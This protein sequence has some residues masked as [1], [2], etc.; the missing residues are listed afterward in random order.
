VSDTH[1]TKHNLP[2]LA[3]RVRNIWEMF[4]LGRRY[5]AEPLALIGEGFATFG[6]IHYYDFRG[7]NQMMIAD[8]EAIQQI[9]VSQAQKF[10]KNADYTDTKRGLARFLGNGLLTNEGDAWKRQRK[11]MQPAFHHKRIEGYAEHIVGST[12]AMVDGW[13][14]QTT[15]PIAEA[16]MALTLRIVVKSLFAAEAD[17]DTEQIGEAMDIIQDFTNDMH[18][19]PTWLPTP[20]ELRARRAVKLLDEVIYR[21]IKRRREEGEDRGDLL[22]MLLQTTD[23]EGIPM[24]D[25][26]IRDELVT[27]YLAGHETTANVLNWT[28]YLLA[29]NSTQRKALQTEID[30][31]LGGR[32][33]TLSDLKRLPYTEQVVKEAMRLYPPAWVFSRMA[34][35]DTVLGGYL[36]PQGS[37]IVVSLYHTHRHTALWGADA[38]Q[39]IPERFAPEREKLIP[40]Y[41]YLPFGAGARICIGNMFA[42]MEAQLILATIVQRVDLALH[43]GQE[44]KVDAKLT[45]RPQGRLPML[46]QRREMQA[47]HPQEFAAVYA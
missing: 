16:L 46:I 32:L 23:E 17:A 3:F 47:E 34:I 41:A 26:Q 18:L 11:L 24:S 42:M 20:L 28:F 15:I 36:I 21:L 45:M 40:R 25:K 6:D 1:I 22:S 31:V 27:L 2:P 14:G 8:P 39:F 30:G 44:V 7:Q 9:T 43:P 5:T 19:L 33:P 38:D 35:E 10:V 4:K 37:T 13:Q 12:T 29:Q